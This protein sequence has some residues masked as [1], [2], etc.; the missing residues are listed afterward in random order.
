MNNFSRL[1][2]RMI[3]LCMYFCD[4]L[5]DFAE[6][7]LSDSDPKV[8]YSVMG[9]CRVRIFRTS[10]SVDPGLSDSRNCMS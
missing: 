10:E 5:I 6:H 1:Y 2:I 3:P 4:C 7:S 8:S 9:M